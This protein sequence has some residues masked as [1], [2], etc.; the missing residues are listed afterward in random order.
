[1][2]KYQPEEIVT[3][4]QS[5]MEKMFLQFIE[6]LEGR[7]NFG[8]SINRL[9]RGLVPEMFRDYLKNQNIENIEKMPPP[10]PEEINELLNICAKAGV[11]FTDME[12]EENIKT[13]NEISDIGKEKK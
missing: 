4:N 12:E 9:N 2:D 6:K 11:E 5:M 8:V 1:M 10:T 13:S 7:E 3:V